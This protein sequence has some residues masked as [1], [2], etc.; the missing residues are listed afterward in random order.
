MKTSNGTNESQ[1]KNGKVLAL[2]CF[3]LMLAGTGAIPGALAASGFNNVQIMIST[4]QSLA[5]TYSVTAYNLTG[6]QVASYQSQFPAAAFELPS[7][8]YLFTVSAVYQ[9]WGSCYCVSPAGASTT[10]VYSNGSTE[11]FVKPYQ[12]QSEYGYLVQNVSASGTYTITTQNTS[13]LSTVPVTV[14]TTFVNGTA[15][16][17]VSVS[18][19]V[20]GQWYYWWGSDSKTTMYAQTGSDGVASLVIPRAPA[21]VTAWGWL[22]VTLDSSHSTVVKNIGGEDINVTVY[23]QPSYVGLSASALVLPPSNSLDLVLHYQQPSYWAMPMGASSGTFTSGGTVGTVA[24]QPT[25]IP[26]LVNQGSQS[27]GNQYY[28]PKSIPSLDGSQGPTSQSGAQGGLGMTPAS[29]LASGVI[30]ASLVVA[31]LASRRNKKS[32]LGS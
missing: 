9:Q 11:A 8:E 32:P 15:A 20:V 31:G 3:A 21:V 22:P 1:A 12:P 30:F 14:K 19:S 24:R 2:A 13:A 10:T 25:G 26:T 27:G 5:Y 4:S 28:L 6:T 18:A 16:A 7:G 29:I 17:G 23:W